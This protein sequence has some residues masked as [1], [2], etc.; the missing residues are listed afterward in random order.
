MSCATDVNY[1]FLDG[2]DSETGG[3]VLF[4]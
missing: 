4:W 1:V 2:L 3:E